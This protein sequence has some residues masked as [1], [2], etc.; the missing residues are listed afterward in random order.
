MNNNITTT[1]KLQ[2]PV[3]WMVDFTGELVDTESHDAVKLAL[4]DRDGKFA[5]QA[6]PITKRKAMNKLQAS[7]QWLSSAIDKMQSME[8]W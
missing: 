3:V 5:P 7:S 2:A 6:K 4:R 1:V 8:S